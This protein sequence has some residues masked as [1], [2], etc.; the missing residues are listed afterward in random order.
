MYIIIILSTKFVEKVNNPLK[1]ARAGGPLKW[2]LPYLFNQN[3]TN[4]FLVNCLKNKKVY[5]VFWEVIFSP[6][7]STNMHV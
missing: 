4:T 1:N 3:Y 7:S 6:L 2:L 5:H